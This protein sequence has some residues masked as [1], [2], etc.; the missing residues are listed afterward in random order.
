MTSRAGRDVALRVDGLNALRRDLRKLPG[1]LADLKDVHQRVGQLVLPEA[2]ARA[3]KRSGRLAGSGRASRAA[4][5][6]SLLFGGARVPWAGP[7]H[8]GWPRRH[9]EPQ[10]FAA[11]AAQATEPAWLALYSVGIDQLVADT[12]ERTY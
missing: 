1:G 10:P 7:I 9:I 4:G 8:W 3:P 2:S 5:R 12:I 11:D 6:V